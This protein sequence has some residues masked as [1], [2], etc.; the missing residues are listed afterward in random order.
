MTM[1]I[2]QNPFALLKASHHDNRQRIMELADAQSLSTYAEACM[3]ARSCLTNPR[4]RLKAE[5]SWFPGVEPQQVWSLLSTL[6]YDP[7]KVLTYDKLPSLAR[8][9]LLAHGLSRIECKSTMILNS[10]S[11]NEIRSKG[12]LILSRG[13][14]QEI[15][16]EKMVTLIDKGKQL[17]RDGFNSFSAYDA[18]IRAAIGDIPGQY[19]RGSYEMLR[20]VAGSDA[21]YMTPATEIDTLL[22]FKS[23]LNSIDLFDGISD[24]K[25]SNIVHWVVL[26]SSAFE[27]IN[28]DQLLQTLNEDRAISE[29]PAISDNAAIEAVVNERRIFY[30]NTI[31]TA[32]DM[33]PS[34]DLVRAVTYIVEGLTKGGSE[35]GPI[36]TSDIVDMYEVEAQAFLCEE[37]KNIDTLIEKLRNSIAKR[38]QHIKPRPI[39]F[40]LIRVVKNWD[41]IAQPIQVMARGKGTSHEPSHRIARKIRN[42]VVFLNN[43]HGEVNMAQHLTNVLKDAFAEVDSIV[44]QTNEDET[45]LEKIARKEHR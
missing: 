20:Y 4:K 18:L 39:L 19:I 16:S 44:E 29:F 5:I 8:A 37:E 42:L 41:R 45:A 17:I 33:L 3:E 25:D 30:R 7:H 27:E 26:I 12:F 10:E 23:R 38:Q 9:N 14:S 32:L 43:K 28:V 2:K 13:E 35:I 6:E 21:R 24:K 36:L 34:V 22:Q 40:A 15:D 1:D 31:R 11:L